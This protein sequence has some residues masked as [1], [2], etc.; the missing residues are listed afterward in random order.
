[1][2]NVYKVCMINIVN[3][4]N[5]NNMLYDDSLIDNSFITR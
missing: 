5:N 3:N 1:M 2:Y 4:N